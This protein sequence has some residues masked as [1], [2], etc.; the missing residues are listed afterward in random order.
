MT[1]FYFNRIA[2][3]LNSPL[4]TGLYKHVSFLETGGGTVLRVP[5]LSLPYS[6]RNKLVPYGVMTGSLNLLCT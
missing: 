5:P 6:C 2:A 3:Q 1:W 4:H